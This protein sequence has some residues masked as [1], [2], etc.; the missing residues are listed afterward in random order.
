[1]LILHPG[2]YMK[3]SLTKYL[4]VI[5]V[6]FAHYNL[7]PQVIN[8]YAKVTCKPKRRHNKNERQK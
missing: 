5:G 6:L 4:M 7:Y 3:K 2:C 8:A 1:M